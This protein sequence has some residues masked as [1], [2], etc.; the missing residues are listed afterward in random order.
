[1]NTPSLKTRIEPKFRSLIVLAPKNPGDP[2]IWVDPRQ[3][4]VSMV[5]ITDEDFAMLERGVTTIERIV[6]MVEMSI[7]DSTMI[8]PENSH[9]VIE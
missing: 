2:A 7:S 9:E 1:M 4:N 5:T 6:P 8:V 3:H